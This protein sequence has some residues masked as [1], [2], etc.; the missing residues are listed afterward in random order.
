MRP[1]SQK[2]TDS[3]RWLW[4]CVAPLKTVAMPKKWHLRARLHLFFAA[5]CRKWYLA[6]LLLGENG[7][8]SRLGR[9]DMDADEDLQMFFDEEDA[10][11]FPLRDF[12]TQICLRATM[13]SS[14]T[15]GPAILPPL[16]RKSPAQT[17]KNLY[18]GSGQPSADGE[19]SSESESQWIWTTLLHQNKLKLDFLGSLISQLSKCMVLSI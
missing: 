7:A 5:M 12:L 3:R 2:L 11:T 9:V 19:S 13:S 15:T 1:R 6:S 17:R 18:G 4:R 10:P 8:W 16:T 14:P